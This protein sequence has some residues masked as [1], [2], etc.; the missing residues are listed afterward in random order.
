LKSNKARIIGSVANQSD[1]VKELLNLAAGK[2]AINVY[3]VGDTSEWIDIAIVAAKFNI[4]LGSVYLARTNKKEQSLANA[5]F[6]QDIKDNK[7]SKN[8]I[9]LIDTRMGSNKFVNNYL[10]SHEYVE[11]RQFKILV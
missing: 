5:K 1:D 9:W 4:T 7:L 8:V 11:W 2:K 6:I 3:P 10:D